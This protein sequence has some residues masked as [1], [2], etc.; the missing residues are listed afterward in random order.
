MLCFAALNTVL[1]MWKIP[2]HLQSVTAPDGNLIYPYIPMFQ[3]AIHSGKPR[4]FPTWTQ[5][6]N[7]SI[8]SNNAIENGL[9]GIILKGKRRSHQFVQMYTNLL[10]VETVIKPTCICIFSACLKESLL[11]LI[12][13]LPP[14]HLVECIQVFCSLPVPNMC[15]LTI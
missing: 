9:L 14:T 2:Y 3:F 6:N 11:A 12:C 7:F 1:R 4:R 13:H 8:P 10:N 15:L 5:E